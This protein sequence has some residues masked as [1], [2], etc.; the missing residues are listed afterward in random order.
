MLASDH[1]P[2][3]DRKEV[4]GRELKQLGVLKNT[5]IHLESFRRREIKKTKNP[6]SW[7]R[8]KNTKLGKAN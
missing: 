7:G 1:R 3:A 4:P 2:Q 8:V 6:S 5:K